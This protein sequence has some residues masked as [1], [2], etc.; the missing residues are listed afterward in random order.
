MDNDVLAFDWIKLIACI[1][2]S[3]S[4][5]YEAQPQKETVIAIF[6]FFKPESILISFS[7]KRECETG[8]TNYHRRQKVSAIKL[9][10]PSFSIF[11]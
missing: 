6:W 1:T 10:Y 4:Y 9:F 5:P 8:F 7:H 2:A 11:E 3:K